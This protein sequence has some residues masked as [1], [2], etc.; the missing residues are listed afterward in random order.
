MTLR[1]NRHC[2]N[3]PTVNTGRETWSQW[4]PVYTGFTV[5]SKAM[6]KE[7]IFIT[8]KITNNEFRKK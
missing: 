2:I 6:K 3:W 7:S 1:Y 8:A 4:W 5:Y